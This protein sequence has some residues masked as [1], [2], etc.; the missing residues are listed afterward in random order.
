MDK[1]ATFPKLGPE[2]IE[3]CGSLAGAVVISAIY[4]V[5][6]YLSLQLTLGLNSVAAFWMGTCHA[7]TGTCSAPDEHLQRPDGHF[8]WT[9]AF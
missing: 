5:L 9:C 7:R 1:G 3:V 4:G 8:A 6:A 2:A